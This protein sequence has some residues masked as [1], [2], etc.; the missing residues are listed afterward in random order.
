MGPWKGA[1]SLA[2]SSDVPPLLAI[3]KTGMVCILHISVGGGAEINQ[4]SSCAIVSMF[5]SSSGSEIEEPP[6]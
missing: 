1:M 5:V 2:P 3:R 6:S 4:S